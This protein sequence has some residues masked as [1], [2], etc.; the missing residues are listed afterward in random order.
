MKS[1]RII[2]SSLCISLI[3][4]YSGCSKS[5]P[6]SAEVAGKWTYTTSD[7]KIKVNF[8]FL[9]SAAG[10]ITINP[11]ATITLNGVTGNAAAQASGINIPDIASISINAN[12]QVFTYAYFIT[13]NSC[14][15]LSDANR[16]DA[17]S[18]SYSATS[19][20]TTSTLGAISIGRP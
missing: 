4:L 2:L 7:S 17:S 1:V 15:F 6:A 5:S 16:I 12:D 11:V 14:K 9:K 18:G 19:N 13:F 20:G 10:V 3:L 8:E